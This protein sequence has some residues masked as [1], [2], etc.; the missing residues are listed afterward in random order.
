[1]FHD[2]PLPVKE[3]M[4]FLERL[5]AEH[6]KDN[7][8]HWQRLRQVPP[9]TGRFL[10]LLAARAPQGKFLEIGTSGGYSGLWI[11]LALRHLAGTLTTFEIREEKVRLAQET[12]S[13]AK[14]DD[15]IE[16]IHG[17]VL[18]FLSKYD[19]VAFCFLD[20]EKEVY[21]TC[22]DILVPNMVTGG[23]LIADNIISH[24]EILEPF[25]QKAFNDK[26]VDALVIPIGNGEL[27]CTKV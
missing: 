26:R 24:K 12:F 23:I 6:R 2:I 8:D 18:D 9:E 10:A 19:G 11:S 17:D 14:V 22:Y 3:R 13:K 21:E 15:I 1:M 5:N 16:I 27:V 7:V 25:A 20:A 4:D